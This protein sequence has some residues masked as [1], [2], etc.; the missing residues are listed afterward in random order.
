[1]EERTMLSG[2]AE[3]LT[4]TSRQLA[5][6]VDADATAYDMVVAAYKLPKATPEQQA[7]RQASIDRALRAAIDVPLSVMR[8]SAAAL[9]DG[10]IVAEHGHRAAASDAAVGLA[11][12]RAGMQGARLNVETNL[13]GIADEEYARTIRARVEEYA[14]SPNR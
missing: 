3:G 2:A 4:A 1:A 9:A 12:L 8:L 5:D 13:S 11:L 10:A 6:A 7:A 14:I